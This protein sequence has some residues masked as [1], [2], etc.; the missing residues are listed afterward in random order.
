MGSERGWRPKAAAW[1]LRDVAPKVALVYLP[2]RLDFC[3]QSE[4]WEC[5]VANSGFSKALRLQNASEFEAVFS[6]NRFKVS[7]RYFLILA[8]P[9][10]HCSRLGIVVAKKNIAKAVQRNR[11]KR[12]IRESFRLSAEIPEG[13]D[14]VVLVR[15]GV[16]TLAND[17][18]RRNLQRLWLDLASRS[19]SAAN[20]AS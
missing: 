1:C 2:D 14:I 9:S 4:N 8:L 7:N 18:I 17:D 10:D 19:N 11:V 16:D 3:A 20:K 12:L 5:T 15:K 13:L 6:R